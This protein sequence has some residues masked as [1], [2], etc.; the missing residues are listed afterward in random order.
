[1][2]CRLSLSRKYIATEDGS[3]TGVCNTFLIFAGSIEEG[4]VK[5]EERV[6]SRKRNI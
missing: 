6:C 2:L 3:L 4:N 5:P 1:M